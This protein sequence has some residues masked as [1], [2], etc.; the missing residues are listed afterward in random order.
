M[1]D[2]TQPAAAD[3]FAEWFYCRDFPALN[4]VGTRYRYGEVTYVG[5]IDELMDARDAAEV[6]P[7]AV[8]NLGRADFIARAR[9]GKGPDAPVIYVVMEISQAVHDHDV[10]R[11]AERAATLRSVGLNAEAWAGGS[12]ISDGTAALARELGV[13]VVLDRPDDTGAD[14][15]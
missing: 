5:D 3:W 10:K 15:A 11:A 12:T 2:H 6:T 13:E 4:R 9:D 1:T 14:A 7:D 8:A